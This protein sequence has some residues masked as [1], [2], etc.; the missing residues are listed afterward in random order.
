MGLY[1]GNGYYTI[2]RQTTAVLY[3]KNISWLVRRNVCRRDMRR[4]SDS[5]A[6]LFALMYL[7]FVRRRY[8]A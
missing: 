7:Y 8:G 1:K 6:V 2:E 5:R 4:V 3:H